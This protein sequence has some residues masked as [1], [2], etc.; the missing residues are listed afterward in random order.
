MRRIAA[1]GGREATRPTAAKSTV[2]QHVAVLQARLGDATE[3]GLIRSN[4]AAGVRIAVPEGDGTGRTVPSD[5]RTMTIDELQRLMTELP[6]R[7]HSLRVPGADRAAHRRGETRCAEDAT[8][9]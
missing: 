2:R 8:S 5:K 9:C 4:P 1:A 3:E 7:L 6:E